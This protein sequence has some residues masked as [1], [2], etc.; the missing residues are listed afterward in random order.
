MAA[1]R[2]CTTPCWSDL[3]T[4]LLASIVQFLELP[5]ALAFAC[6]CTSWRAASGDIPH[7]RTPWLM[8]WE[9]DPHPAGGRSRSAV[10]CKLRNLLDVDRVHSL[11]FP[12]GTFVT[13]CGASNGWLV[14]VDELCNLSL[15]NP[16]TSQ[17]IPLPPVTDFP[18]V[19]AV[20]PD[21]QGKI[22]AYRLSRSSGQYIDA[23]QYDAYH[24][25]TY[26]YWKA[27][28]S[29]DPSGGGDYAVTVVH[30]GG[31]WISHV[32]CPTTRGKSRLTDSA[33]ARASTS[34]HSST[35][36]TIWPRISTGR[37][38]CPATRPE[39]ATTP[40]R[41][42]TSAAGLAPSAIEDVVMGGAD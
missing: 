32:S 23:Q 6:V 25:A 28:L 39:A 8:S 38:S 20:V 40:S 31:R 26:F 2:S 3:P 19:T 21:D 10:T 17:T 27:E 22:K 12:A 30:F 1:A 5:G 41:S 16:F 36:R 35:T 7:P 14:V 33:G 13:C 29:G 37:R 42:S 15:H 4:D 24:L 34:T 11:T 18:C 9:P